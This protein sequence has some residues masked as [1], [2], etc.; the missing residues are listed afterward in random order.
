MDVDVLDEQIKLAVEELSDEKNLTKGQ[1]IKLQKA[2]R[3]AIENGTSPQEALGIT[4]GAV[5][6]IYA[7]AYRLYQGAKYKDAGYIFHFLQSLN[8]KDYRFYLGMGACLHRLENYQ[9]AAFMYDIAGALD[10][11][12]PMPYYY[13]S[14]CR[15][16]MGHFNAAIGLLQLVT[17]RCKDNPQYSAILDRALMTINSIHL[18]QIGEKKG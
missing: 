7:H 4:K 9:T 10:K 8:P 1:A 5:E 13:S 11:E 6:M 2:L 12:N 17:E 16:K 14:D 15:I 3:E 18:Q